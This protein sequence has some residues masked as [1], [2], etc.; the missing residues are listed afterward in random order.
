MSSPSRT[1]VMPYEPSSHFNWSVKARA[2]DWAVEGKG[3]NRRF[4]S[5]GQVEWGRRMRG[6]RKR[7]R[8]DGPEP[9]G[10]VLSSKGSHSWGIR[11]YS[12]RSDRSRHIAYNYNNWVVCFS[13]WAHSLVHLTLDLEPN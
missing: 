2:C 7:R 5:V 3:G 10:E 12:S 6:Q 9:C 1:Q 4:E 8:H 13:T 11:Q